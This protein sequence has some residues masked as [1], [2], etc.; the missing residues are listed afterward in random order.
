MKMN[1]KVCV[2]NRETTC[3]T[4]ALSMDRWGTFDIQ[5]PKLGLPSTFNVQSGRFTGASRAAKGFTLIELL[6]VIAVIT[7][8]A[9]LTLTVIHGIEKTKNINIARAELEQISSALDNYKNQYGVYPPS[10]PQAVTNTLATMVNPLYYEL[11]GV[12]NNLAKQ[13]YVTLDGASSVSY[14]SYTAA[15]GFD[16]GGP[17]N[18]AKPGSDSENAK[19]RNFLPGLKSTLIGTNNS[20]ALNLL[21]TSVRGPDATYMPQGPGV[22]DMNPFRYVYP[23]TNNPNSYDLWVKLQ[24]SGNTYLI[25][26]WTKQNIVNSPLP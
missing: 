13:A 16:L 24:I 12:T 23:G 19:A 25:C 11:V 14:N 6:V 3:L 17:I 2:K 22:Q 1:Q 9:G 18:C 4:P 5:Q 21:V 10:N 26:N 7:I 15:N 8:I 20:G